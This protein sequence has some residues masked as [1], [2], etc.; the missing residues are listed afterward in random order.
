M[1]GQRLLG[2]TV[3]VS[4]EGVVPDAAEIPTQVALETDAVKAR[5]LDPATKLNVW[6]DGGVPPTVAVKVREHPAR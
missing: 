3:T 6:A 1:P 5:L 4:D 2:S